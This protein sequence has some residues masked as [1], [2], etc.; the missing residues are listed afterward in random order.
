MGSELRC[1]ARAGGKKGEGKALLETSEILFRGD[2]KEFRLKVAFAS[3]KKVE[4]RAGRLELTTA[5][6]VVVLEL[7]DAAAKWAD[8]I[9]NP[10]SR[11][12]KLGVKAGMRVAVI[13][14][15]DPALR[16]ELEA[17]GAE[18]TWGK[19]AAGAQVIF[20]GANAAKD[21]E[22]LETLKGRLDPAGAI[23]IVRPK[24]SASI[25]E[26]EVMARGKAAGLVDVKVV[27]F[28]ATHTAE[29]YVIPLAKRKLRADT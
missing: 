2:A 10:R 25:S 27:A 14:V 4:A 13:G 5:E 9:K 12:D 28:S 19:A 3:V 8:K 20:Y 16:G 1:V 11:I 7:G 24:G 6:G 18:V 21:L 23:W 17:R 22:R 15:D 29:K 26:A